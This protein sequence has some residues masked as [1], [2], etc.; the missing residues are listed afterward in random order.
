M[1]GFQSPERKNYH[2]RQT[3]AVGVPSE[4]GRCGDTRAGDQGQGYLLASDPIP[5]PFPTLTACFGFPELI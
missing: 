4:T 2:E 3:A 5:G 1:P